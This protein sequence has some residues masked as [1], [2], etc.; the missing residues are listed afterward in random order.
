MESWRTG[1][2]NLV[3]HPNGKIEIEGF[4]NRVPSRMFK[5]KRGEGIGG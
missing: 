3:S 5:S 2:L 4:E 1:I